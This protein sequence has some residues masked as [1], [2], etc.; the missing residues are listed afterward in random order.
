MRNRFVSGPLSTLTTIT[1]AQVFAHQLSQRTWFRI[2]E[3]RGGKR[4][5]IS[6]K[7]SREYCKRWQLFTTGNGHNSFIKIIA[8]HIKD[9]SVRPRT[10]WHVSASFDD[11]RLPNWTSAASTLALFVRSII[12]VDIPSVEEC[13]CPTGGLAS[14]FVSC[15]NDH[16]FT[17]KRLF[18]WLKSSCDFF[19][20]CQICSFGVTRI[21]WRLWRNREAIQYLI[22]SFEFVNS[23]SDP[24]QILH[25]N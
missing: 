12:C 3:K 9:R 24:E 6:R 11:I 8:I 14:W 2:T 19:C 23:L 18:V 17:W 16:S 5:N 13:Y 15:Q 22:E 20:L 25:M 21:I 7:Q 1:L 10:V 4:G